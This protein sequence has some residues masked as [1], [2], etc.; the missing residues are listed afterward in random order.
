MPLVIRNKNKL[1]D[2]VYVKTIQSKK[3]KNKKSKNKN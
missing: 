2:Y 3:Q 1:T